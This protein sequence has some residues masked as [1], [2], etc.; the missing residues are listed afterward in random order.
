MTTANQLLIKKAREA[1]R[2]QKRAEAAEAKQRRNKLELIQSEIQ[3]LLDD[4]RAEGVDIRT[5]EGRAVA[6][7]VIAQKYARLEEE[8]DDGNFG[9][10]PLI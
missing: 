6:N 5:P 7:L 9:R 8:S 1:V 2:N 10:G 4:L 3:L